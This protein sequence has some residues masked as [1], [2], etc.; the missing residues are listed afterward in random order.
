MLGGEGN[1]QGGLN[2]GSSVGDEANAYGDTRRYGVSSVD[3]PVEFRREL[4]R[5]GG[6]RGLR[7][8][9]SF[10]KIVGQPP[11]YPVHVPTAEEWGGFKGH[12]PHRIYRSRIAQRLGPTH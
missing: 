10:R 11:R 7:S 9:S 8:R 5:T 2:G 1:E 6:G 4:I 3:I 12:R